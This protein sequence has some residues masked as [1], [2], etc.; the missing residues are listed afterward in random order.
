MALGIGSSLWLLESNPGR[1]CYDFSRRC[2]LRGVFVG[3][4]ASLALI[5]IRGVAKPG[6][7]T[8]ARA[9]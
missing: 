8:V 6:S 9:I 1:E 3:R 7:G 2:D 4:G 5:L